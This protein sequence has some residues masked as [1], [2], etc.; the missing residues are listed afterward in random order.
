MKVV[1][2]L[3]DQQ[4]ISVDR[5]NWLIYGASV[6]GASHEREHI[7]NQDSIY[8]R[9]SKQEDIGILSVAD[10]HGSDTY[11]RSKFGSNIAA[12]IA[13]QTM[14]RFI[15]QCHSSSNTFSSVRDIIRYSI[16]R[17]LVKNWNNRVTSHINRNPFTTYELDKFLGKKD[18]S[19]KDKLERHPQIA[20]GSTLLT[21]AVTKDYF[22]FFQI[23]DGNILV[24][25]EHRNVIAPF[26]KN[27]NDSDDK[28]SVV[29]L[30][31]TDSL[32]MESSWLRFKVGIYSI[33]D[34][35][36]RLI[37]LTTDGY[38]NSFKDETGFRKIGTD[39]LDILDNYGQQYIQSKLEF[40]LKETSQ[41]GSGDDI[42]LGYLYKINQ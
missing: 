5:R 10:G 34:L 23:G 24:V 11:F 36:P 15:T 8:W 25:D 20:Y 38:Y 17:I 12:K 32:C 3:S 7:S 27:I 42:T 31:T 16:P 40:L 4:Y 19:S 22:L 9:Y 37:L 28:K 41:K 33:Y 35:K 18:P 14:F 6:R 29:T 26:E 13:T 39:Y 2:S 30:N 1:G 21:V